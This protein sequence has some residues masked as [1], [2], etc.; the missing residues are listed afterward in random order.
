MPFD[1]RAFR[2]ALGC[3]ASGVTVITTLDAAQRPV[4]VTVSAFS[5]LSLDPPMVLFCLG[6]STSNLEAFRQG[7]VSI[8]ILAEGQQDLSIRFASRGVDKFAGLEMDTA[9]GGVPAPK[10][11][12]ARLDCV[13]TQT[14]EGGDHLI[15][16][17]A[18]EDLITRTGGQPLVY[19]RGSYTQVG[20][21]PV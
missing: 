20:V 6:K 3:F 17:C 14:I 9:P 2:K 16:L 7:P 10:D 18:V 1:D 8:S 15:V 13:I 11:V 19:F 12:L 21:L 5:S 4:G